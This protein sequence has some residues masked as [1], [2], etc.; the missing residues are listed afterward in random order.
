MP[1]KINQ[2]LSLF[3]R[4]LYAIFEEDLIV[5]GIPGYRFSPPSN[6]FANSTVNPANAGFCVPAGNCLGSGVL[7][8]STCKQGGKCTKHPISTGKNQKKVSWC[9]RVTGSFR[10][11][12]NWIFCAFRSSH[13]NVLT[14]LLPGGWEACSGC[15]WH[16]TYEGGAPDYDWYQ[17]GRNSTSIPRW[18]NTLHPKVK[19][20]SLSTSAEVSGLCVTT[21]CQYDS[22]LRV[23]TLF[24]SR[25]WTISAFNQWGWAFFFF[26]F[27]QWLKITA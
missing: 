13:H 14:P 6:V 8:I 2:R 5:K 17:S 20:R 12:S 7:N 18:R 22:L 25:W 19:I 24:T 27:K 11:Y 15:V 10:S 3:Q 4:S 23:K 16:E 9:Q 1:G 26:L 21:W